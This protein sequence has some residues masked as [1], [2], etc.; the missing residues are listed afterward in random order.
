MQTLEEPIPTRP[1]FGTVH[2]VAAYLKLPDVGVES[3]LMC[4][5]LPH[6]NFHG[7]VRI[8]WSDVLKYVAGHSH[9]RPS[10]EVRHA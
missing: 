9:T 1:G 5:E 3:L 8:A 2:E 4:G 10:Q 6:I 7:A